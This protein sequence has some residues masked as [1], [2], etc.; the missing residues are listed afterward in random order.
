MMTQTLTSKTESVGH[1]KDGM[2]EKAE[3]G[4]GPQGGDRD[5]QKGHKEGK[6]EA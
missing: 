6:A 1:G 2:E 3:A 5:G 4:S